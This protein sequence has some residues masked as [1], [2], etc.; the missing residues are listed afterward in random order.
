MKYTKNKIVSGAAIL[1]LVAFASV[2]G[3]SASAQV[4][5]S[6][7]QRHLHSKENKH[8]LH[9]AIENNDY[10]LFQELTSGTPLA[11]KI[12]EANFAKLVEAHA[13]LEAG[14]YEAAGE[15]FSELGIKRH[16]K[17]MHKRVS[18]SEEDRETLRALR[19]AGDTEGA[20]ALMEELGIRP[21]RMK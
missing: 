4:D 18:L 2:S 15:I 17:R 12:T 13:L 7:V 9:A 3:L 8:A 1:S 6:A 19:E 16:G 21:H 11:E 20:K 14:D 5:T 10:S